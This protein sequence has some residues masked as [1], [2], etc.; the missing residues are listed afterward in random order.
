MIKHLIVKSAFDKNLWAQTI[1]DACETLSTEFLAELC[2]I[3]TTSLNKW[4]LGIY[5]PG[6]EYPNMTN[7]LSVCNALDLNPALFFTTLD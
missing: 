4:K 1:T 3:S 2:D 7:F 6:F 5:Q